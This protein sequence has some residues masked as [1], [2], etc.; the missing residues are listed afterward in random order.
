MYFLTVYLNFN[1]IL[2]DLVLKGYDTTYV[3]KN[4]WNHIRNFVKYNDI[5]T[6]SIEYK[7]IRVEIST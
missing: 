5:N 2:S 1:K 7:S 4:P 6:I 3:I